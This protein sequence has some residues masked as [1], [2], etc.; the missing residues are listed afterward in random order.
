MAKQF[1]T[2]RI[3]I[4]KANAA[5]VMAVAAAA[6]IVVFSLVASKALLDQRAYQSKVISMKEK[7]RDTLKQNISSVE[8]LK[9]SYQEFADA[10]ENVLGGNPDG[11]SDKD[12]DNPRIVLDALPSEYDF[13]ALTTSLEKL[14][15]DN[16]FDIGS[17]TGTDQ[18][19]IYNP[20]ANGVSAPDPNDPNSSA[21]TGTP[22]EIPA[23]D[24]NDSSQAIQ[25]PFEL[26][27]IASPSRGGNLINL[28]E[29]SIRP[30]QI[31]KVSATVDS[32][33][34]KVTIAGV[35]Y[36][37]PARKLDVKTEVVQ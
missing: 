18:E 17:I 15:K 10:N 3:A 8:T 31:Q 24:P 30:F 14:L 27:A 12:G 35:T 19:T 28:F 22:V 7:A 16:N 20:G 36:F 13:P 26:E 6:F 34:L 29:R 33:Q 5:V 2:K 21:N 9:L 1:S 25:I 23:G 37:L 32:G 11:K 4:D